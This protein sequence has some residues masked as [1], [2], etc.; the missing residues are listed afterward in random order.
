MK[1]KDLLSHIDTKAIVE[2]IAGVEKACSSEVRV[3]IEPKLRGRD[4]RAVAERTFERL[5]I[6]RTRL[7]NG[8]LLFIAAEDQK[9]AILG[10]KG[11]DERVP[12]N[13]WNDTAAALTERFKHQEFT[14]GILEAIEKVGSQLACYF[15]NQQGDV[16]EL[17]NE[18]SFGNATEDRGDPPPTGAS[19]HQPRR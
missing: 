12:P 5:G 17:S 6:T 10:D 9:F 15:P 11:I 16:N 18:V 4:I 19:D 2:A 3:H 7:R 13:F 8:V 1:Q 14:L